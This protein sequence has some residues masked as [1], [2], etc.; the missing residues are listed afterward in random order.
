MAGRALTEKE[1]FLIHSILPKNRSGY[2]DYREKIEAMTVLSGEED[3]ILL[4]KKNT[5]LPTEIDKGG[6]FA[7]GCTGLNGVK[8]RVVIFEEIDDYIEIEISE[9]GET[10]SEGVIWTYSTWRP[11]FKAPEDRSYVREI[12]LIKNKLVIAIAPKQKKIWAFDSTTGVNFILPIMNFYN[13]IMRAR[14]EKNPNVVLNPNRI[15]ENL[16]EFSDEEIGQ[17]FLLYNEYLNKVEIDYGLF[18]P[19]KVKKVFFKKIF[20]KQNA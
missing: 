16:E 19:Q 1:L 2:N 4:G 18:K 11:G 17:G 3:S 5:A 12:H 9:E 15:F 20:G 8:Y 14:G 10:E 6:I 7:I 13:E